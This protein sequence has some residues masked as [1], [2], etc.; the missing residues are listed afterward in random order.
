MFVLLIGTNTM[1]S[2]TLSYADYE[3]VNKQ[4]AELCEKCISHRWNENKG[5]SDFE[6][7]QITN[8]ENEC[9]KKVLLDLIEQNY[10]LKKQKNAKELLLKNWKTL[11]KSYIE[12]YNNIATQ[13]R[14]CIDNENDIFS[15][16]TSSIL[17]APSIWQIQLK[18]MI[19]FIYKYSHGY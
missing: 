7:S 17:I 18:E 10:S 4:A 13:S 9:L 5:Y 8:E 11:E 1:A 19:T 16:G 6:M 14:R 15:C 12:F 2:D 3:Q